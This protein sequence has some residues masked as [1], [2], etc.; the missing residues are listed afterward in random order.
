MNIEGGSFRI[1]VSDGEGAT[2]PRWLDPAGEREALRQLL[3]ETPAG[4]AVL[5]LGLDHAELTAPWAKAA[6]TYHGLDFRA[7]ARATMQAALPGATVQA[8]GDGAEFPVPAASQ[9]LILSCFYLERLPM[10][11]LYMALAELRRT[12]KPGGRALLAS[13]YPGRSWPERLTAGFYRRLGRGNP[14]RLEHYLSPEEWEVER[15]AFLTRGG[16]CVQLLWLSRKHEARPAPHA[17]NPAPQ[18]G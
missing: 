12:L 2:F 16:R 11:Q 10:H 14:L 9:D 17:G 6:R 13:L 15:E 7:D 4:G 8:P 18:P 1:R 5:Q 3:A